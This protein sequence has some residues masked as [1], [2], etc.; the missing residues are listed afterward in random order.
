MITFARLK[1]S[2]ILAEIS[3]RNVE[4]THSHIDAPQIRRRRYHVAL[5]T[6]FLR[7]LQQRNLNSRSISKLKSS[8]D[9]SDA[10]LFSYG[11]IIR[12]LENELIILDTLISTHANLN[13]F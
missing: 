10:Y 1:I 3:H 13:E 8:P 7:A 5:R 11:R 4:L 12:R 6:E 2:R 9:R